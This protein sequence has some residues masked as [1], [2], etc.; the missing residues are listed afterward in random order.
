MKMEELVVSSGAGSLNHAINIIIARHSDGHRPAIS[1]TG[2]CATGDDNNGKFADNLEIIPNK[3]QS[4]NDQQSQTDVHGSFFRSL[5]LGGIFTEEEYMRILEQ[6]AKYYPK[7]SKERYTAITHLKNYFRGRAIDENRNEAEREQDFSK[8]RKYIIEGGIDPTTG[9]LVDHEW[10][11]TYIR[12]YKKFCEDKKDKAKAYSDLC[13]ALRDAANLD[14]RHAFTFQKMLGDLYLEHQDHLKAQTAYLQSLHNLI[15]NTTQ[16]GTAEEGKKYHLY[17]EIHKNLKMIFATSGAQE[18]IL[19]IYTPIFKHE[20]SRN[21]IYFLIYCFLKDLK[22]IGD[23]LDASQIQPMRK[24]LLGA[25]EK[26]SHDDARPVG[27]LKADINF[28]FDQVLK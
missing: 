5:H 11:M 19:D 9:C 16:E 23:R 8:M 21:I 27:N 3:Q 15:E 17:L 6:I 7:F 12:L 26:V 14:Q 2:I 22:E 13:L 25:A 20:Q 1:M 10:L 18:T 24:M 28:H 4:Q